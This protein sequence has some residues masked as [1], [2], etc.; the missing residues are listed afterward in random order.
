MIQS[1]NW[2]AGKPLT[3]R[4]FREALIAK[5]G[6]LDIEKAKADVRPFIREVATIEG[7][8]RELFI[9]AASRIR[10]E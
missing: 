8:S 3:E 9:T 2:E 7:W 4:E 5:I 10:V 6:D 1:G